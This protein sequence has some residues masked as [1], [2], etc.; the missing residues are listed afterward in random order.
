MNRYGGT[1]KQL[2]RAW[3]ARITLGGVRCARCGDPIEPGQKWDLGHDDLDPSRY[4]GPEHQGCNRATNGR[5]PRQRRHSRA[6]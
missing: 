2:R 1:H 5:R 3:A 6:W 4:A